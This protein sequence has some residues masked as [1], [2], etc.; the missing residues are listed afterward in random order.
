MLSWTQTTLLVTQLCW[1][2]AGHFP[3]N[4]NPSRLHNVEEAREIYDYVIVG[5]G[6]A[7]LTVGDR[8][9]EGGRCK[10]ATRYYLSRSSSLKA[11]PP[12]NYESD[13]V[14]AIEYGYL[15]MSSPVGNGSDAA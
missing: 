8:L 14:L 7:G 9:S 1:L 12:A 10:L 3:L 6:T 15:G 13:S 11:R 5:A 2:V 4:A